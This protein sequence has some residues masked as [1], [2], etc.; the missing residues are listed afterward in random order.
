MHN[1]IMAAGSRDHPLVLAT[2]RYA[3]WQ[4]R[5][6]RYIK[7]RS[8]GDALRKCILEGPYI[9]STVTILAVPTIDDSLEVPKRTAV[10]TLLNMSPKNKDHYQ[11]ENNA[12]HLLLTG[13]GD[14][15]YSTVDACKTTHDMWIAIERL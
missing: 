14:E 12:I 9:P 10:E 11:S 15:I 3:Q 8:N 13:I 6:L 7:I 5:F 4:S 2:G 1:N